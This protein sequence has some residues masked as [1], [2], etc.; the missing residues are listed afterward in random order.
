MKKLLIAPLLAAMLVLSGAGSAVAERPFTVPVE[1]SFVDVDPC[2]GLAHE[3]TI[4]VT[5]YVHEHDGVI[6]ARGVRTL[7]TSSGYAGKGTSSFVLNNSVE[8]F[9]STD[10]LANDSGDRI[11]AT[12]VFVADL[13]RESVRIDRFTLEC[14]G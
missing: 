4:A 8:M 3:V 13:R 12:V 6:A 1:E 10:V 9:R 2:S 7:T 11:R 14:L 5:F